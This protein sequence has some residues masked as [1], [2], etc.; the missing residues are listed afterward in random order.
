MYYETKLLEASQSSESSGK[1]LMSTPIGS[2]IAET[3][4]CG[5]NKQTQTF[6]KER[7]LLNAVRCSHF[8]LMVSIE[9]LRDGGNCI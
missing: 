5:G 6:Q 9:E 1:S 2:L 7:D 3:F 4:A 8:T